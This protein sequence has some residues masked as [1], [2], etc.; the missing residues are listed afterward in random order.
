MSP[1]FSFFDSYF[2]DEAPLESENEVPFEKWELP[3]SSV[4]FPSVFVSLVPLRPGGA[5]LRT[6][7][8][9][10]C[11][12]LVCVFFPLPPL[13]TLPPDLYIK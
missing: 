7:F 9:F 1:F 5:A 11:P 2:C 10:S 3:D 8:H 13:F 6:P 4:T 12:P